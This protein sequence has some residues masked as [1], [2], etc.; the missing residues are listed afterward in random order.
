MISKPKRHCV[1]P[2]QKERARQTFMKSAQ[3]AGFI[4]AASGPLVKPGIP[5]KDEIVGQRKEQDHSS[6]NGGDGEQP[7]IDPIIQGLLSRLPKSGE[8]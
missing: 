4:E 1:S 5:Q 2:K 6:E 7:R 8:V 3:Y